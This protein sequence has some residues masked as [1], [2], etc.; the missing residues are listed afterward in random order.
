[1]TCSQTTVGAWQG[2]EQQ[3]RLGAAMGQRTRPLLKD[4]PLPPHYLP[5]S[6]QL[7]TQA[8][9]LCHSSPTV[10]Y[11]GVMLKCRGKLFNQWGNVEVTM[12][13]TQSGCSHILGTSITMGAHVELLAHCDSSI[14]FR[15]PACQDT[16]PCAVGEAGVLCSHTQN[17]IWLG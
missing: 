11:V 9:V 2:M 10:C 14:P 4:V 16:A 3:S 15:V 7:P 13:L 8:L 17:C 1:C 5:A 12:G 6:A